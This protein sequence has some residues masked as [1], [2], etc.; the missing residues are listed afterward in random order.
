MELICTTCDGLGEERRQITH[1][2][3]NVYG[4]FRR[5]NGIYA[6][7]CERCAG[8][9]FVLSGPSVPIVPAD[10]PRRIPPSRA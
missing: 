1:P 5:G 7:P 6:R 8:T 10:D 9:G 3:Q 2:A 4:W